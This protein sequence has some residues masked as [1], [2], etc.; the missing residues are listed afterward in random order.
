M[1]NH[2]VSIKI[3]QEYL[4]KDNIIVSGRSLLRYMEVLVDHVS[5]LGEE[6][7]ISRGE[8][9]K[10]I[11]KLFYKKSSKDHLSTYEVNSMHL[12]NNFIPIAVYQPRKES[13]DKM[14]NIL[15][16]HFS[17]SKLEENIEE[18]L[19]AYYN[20]NFHNNK[21]TNHDDVA[22]ESLINTIVAKKQ[23]TISKLQYDLTCIPKKYTL[24]DTPLN[25]L[26]IV[27]HHGGIYICVYSEGYDK[28]FILGVE[29]L[30]T[31]KILNRTY[32]SN[33]T[34]KIVTEYFNTH[35]GVTHNID[36]NNYTIEIDFS[37]LTG[38]FIDKHYWHPSQKMIMQ[39]NGNYRLHLTCGINRE[40][41]SWILIWGAN[42]SVIKPDLL[43]QCVLQE[44]TL[45]STIN[46]NQSIEYYTPGV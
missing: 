18:N 20:T 11:W 6:I 5:I 29:E 40:L 2:V 45:M 10:K 15:H 16:N 32:K 34:Q 19:G 7:E 27:Y 36:S 39:P 21:Y 23:I 17:K 25:P 9:N 46:N 22:L 12:L 41:I 3:L 24:I 31:F 44:I 43:K 13:I 4:E 35:F 38:M 33:H 26:K 14:Q 1:R 8:K 28:L 30:V 37:E 42:A